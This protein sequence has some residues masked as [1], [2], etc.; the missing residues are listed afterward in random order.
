M[1]VSLCSEDI[2]QL[3]GVRAEDDET[4]CWLQTATFPQAG[5]LEP[6]CERFLNKLGLC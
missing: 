5:S 4:F 6:S 3:D 2:K 1:H